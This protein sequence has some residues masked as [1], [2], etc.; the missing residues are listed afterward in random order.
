[1]EEDHRSQE[2]RD[3]AV[4]EKIRHSDIRAGYRAW[5]RS[6]LFDGSLTCRLVVDILVLQ[7]KGGKDTSGRIQE[8]Q[9]E[10]PSLTQCHAKESSRYRQ[11]D[12][13][14]VIECLIAA[15][16]LSQ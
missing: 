14:D 3:T 5:K 9:A 4:A 7:P 8:E 12:L 2:N 15:D 11:H 10:D 13:A 16:P 6:S 1:V